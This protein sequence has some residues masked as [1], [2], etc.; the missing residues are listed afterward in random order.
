MELRADM[1]MHTKYSSD[2][3]LEPID[4]LRKSREEGLDVIGITDHNTT[5]GA[6]ETRKLSK[7]TP[8]VIIGQEVKT[9]EGEVMVFGPENDIPPHMG[10]LE[11]VKQA[12]KMRGFIVI[13]HPFDRMRSSVGNRMET[14]LEYI[15]AVE[16]F[17]SS[18][19]WNRFNRKAEE[20]TEK[21]GLPPIIGSD[22]HIEEE[23]GKAVMLI[24][25]EPTQS[26]VLNAIK[27]KKT[28]ILVKKHGVTGYLGAYTKRVK[29]KI[30]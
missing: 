9:G 13:P 18:C 2:S 8:L 6:L 29:N 20:F 1:H 28:K 25:S 24:N 7:G 17:N 3:N 10:L 27:Q 23:I 21:K 12:R 5:R 19:L 26:S 22:A 16:V 30:M 14:I 15:D 11:T 4:I